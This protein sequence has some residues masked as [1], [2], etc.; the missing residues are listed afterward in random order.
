MKLDKNSNCHHRNENTPLKDLSRRGVLKKAFYSA[1]VLL[2][3]GQLTRPP[4]AHAD[5]SGGPEGP[6]NDWPG[7][8]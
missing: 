5:A 1:P 2:A 3:L 8:M 7:F 6:P 4:N